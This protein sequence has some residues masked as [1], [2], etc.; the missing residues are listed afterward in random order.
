MLPIGALLLA[1]SASAEIVER[2]VTYTLNDDNRTVCEGFLAFDTSIVVDAPGVAII[3]QW[4]GLGSTEKQHA[5]DLAAKGYV[6]FAVDMYGAGCRGQPCGPDTS[7]WLRENP[8]ELRARAQ[9][10]LEVLVEQ[11]VVNS[12]LL[13]ANGY[14]FGG[15]VVLEMARAGLPLVGVSSFHGG[16]LP[17]TGDTAIPE[18]IAV[19]VHTG[20]L[21]PITED[22]LPSLE[23]E[24]RDAELLRWGTY[25]YGNCAHGWTD[26]NSNN[27]REREGTEAHDSMFVFYSQI[28]TGPDATNTGQRN[29]SVT[30]GFA[31]GHRAALGYVGVSP[32]AAAQADLASAREEIAELRAQLKTASG[33]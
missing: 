20:D 25:N 26:P 28:F 22:E 33:V 16:L 8:E 24:L 9:R 11:P 7:R 19:Q 1:S 14:C 10:G 15:T 29:V 4:Q 21:D 6:G 32:L 13:G 2:S 18:Q 17:L 27:Y 31:E 30:A 23:Q 5:R 3:H 12:E